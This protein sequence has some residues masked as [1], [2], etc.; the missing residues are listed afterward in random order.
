[1]ELAATHSYAQA[2]LQTGKSNTTQSM[3]LHERFTNHTQCGRMFARTTS[4]SFGTG[5]ILLA[6]AALLRRKTP[7]VFSA[8]GCSRYGPCRRTCWIHSYCSDCLTLIS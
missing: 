7:A 2:I 5:R 4:C 6:L 1:M 3:V 8:A